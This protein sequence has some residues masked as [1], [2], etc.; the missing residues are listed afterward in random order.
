L[1]GL[2]P[3]IANLISRYALKGEECYQPPLLLSDEKTES[4]FNL[5]AFLR[6]A[7]TLMSTVR[8]CK[9]YLKVRYQFFLLL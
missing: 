6:N 1:L 2:E 7:A 8:V 4:D 3:N 5:T 9:E